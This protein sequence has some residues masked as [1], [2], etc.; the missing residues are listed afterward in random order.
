[1]RRQ[2][3]IILGQH[4][5][6]LQQNKA[7]EEQ[8]KVLTSV[9]NKVD[10]VFSTDEI[11]ETRGLAIYKRRHEVTMETCGATIEETREVADKVRDGSITMYEST[12]YICIIFVFVIKLLICLFV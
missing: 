10:R 4:D 3:N 7:L 8:N 1:M 12:Q 6:I 2:Q 5:V 11:V 9:N